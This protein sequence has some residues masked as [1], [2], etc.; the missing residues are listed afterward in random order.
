VAETSPDVC[1]RHPKR[2]SWV[3]CSRCGRTICPECQILT[4]AGVRCPECVQETGGSV[5]WRGAGEARRPATKARPARAA[6]S[7]PEAGSGW[8]GGLGQMLRPGSEAP[9]IT[10]GLI[11]IVVVLWIGGLFTGGLPFLVLAAYPSLSLQVWRFF[12]AALVYPPEF[13]FVISI[14]LTGFFFLLTA[15]AV[16][17]NLG[18]GRFLV[19]TL[20]AAGA[21]SAAMV[22][23]GYPAYGLSGVLFGMF[24]AYLIF[25]W[26]YPPARAQALIII[27]VNLLINIALG[28]FTLPQIVAGLIVGAGATYLFRRYDDSRDSKARTPYLIIGAVVVGLI[29]IA[30]VRTLL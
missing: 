12:T 2:E 25:V 8:R 4:P 30:V 13:L 5:T 29:L 7:R 22:L 21:G 14:L 26:S 17:K 10:W 24:G 20:G 23:S 11:G 28:G 1:Y 3:L 15:P 16:E 27:G 19:L 9:V 6:R 18:R